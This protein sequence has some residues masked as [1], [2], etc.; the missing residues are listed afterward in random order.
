[1]GLLFPYQQGH[2]EEPINL[3][4]RSEILYLQI[5]CLPFFAY[6]T[7]LSQRL[8][9]LSSHDLSL[10]WGK[11][12]LWGSHENYEMFLHEKN[13]HLCKY[14][15]FHIQF[16]GNE[17]ASKKEAI[18]WLQGTCLTPWPPE[19]EPFPKE[20]EDPLF[21]VL[22]FSS[23]SSHISLFKLLIIFSLY[24]K[25]LLMAFADMEL[26]LTKMRVHILPKL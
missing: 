5:L 3:N 15:L 11:D 18:K 23:L 8:C 4:P 13:V 16:Q 6:T 7:W 26:I 25:T 24:C 1:M 12:P 17:I 10:L 2:S 20:S 19:E 9:L 14:I 21:H 22:K